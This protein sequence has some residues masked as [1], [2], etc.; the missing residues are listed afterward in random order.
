MRKRPILYAFFTHNIRS[1]LQED[2]QSFNHFTFSAAGRTNPS[3]SVK[4]V[5]SVFLSLLPQAKQI[6][7]YPY[8]QL[9]PCSSLSCRRQKKS[10]L[11]RPIRVIVHLHRLWPTASAFPFT[12]LPQA[13]QIRPYPYNQLN[14]CSS[15]FSTGKS[16]PSL[17][18]QSV[19]SVFL[20]L[21]PQAKIPP[22]YPIFSDSR[23]ESP[24]R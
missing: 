18:V 20:S 6:C 15:L 14:P 5:P 8:N 16:N 22:Y 12:H 11:I 17:S 3:L 1:N 23:S 13:E 2:S 21:L 4:S 19:Q 9:N 7:P 24:H 10:A